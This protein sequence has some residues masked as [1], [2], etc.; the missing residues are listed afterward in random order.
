MADRHLGVRVTDARYEAVRDA[1]Y[2]RRTSH[3]AV[4]EEALDAWRVLPYL[5]TGGTAPLVVNGDEWPAARLCFAERDGM[6]CD[7]RYLHDGD[8]VDING[9]LPGHTWSDDDAPNLARAAT[10]ARMREHARTALR[11]T[12]GRLVPGRLNQAASDSR[13]DDVQPAAPTASDGRSA[14]EGVPAGRDPL[15]APHGAAGRAREAS[16]TLPTV[17]W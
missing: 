7:R 12:D 2:Q 4:V 14:P 9:P 13:P 3:R 17:D 10:V 8:H 6:L 15:E 5:A 16:E 11:D 1:A